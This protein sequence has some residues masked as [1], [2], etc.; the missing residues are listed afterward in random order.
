MSYLLLNGMKEKDSFFFKI[1]EIIENYL[2]VK[3]VE[4]INLLEKEIKPCLG[5]FKCWVQTPGICIIDDFGRDVAK[6]YIQSDNVIYLTSIIFGNFSSELKK[7]VDRTLPLTSPFF[8]EYEGTMCHESRYNKYPNLIAFGILN[9]PDKTEEE[10]FHSL[11]EKNADSRFSLKKL[12]KVIY[13]TDDY[14]TIKQKIES[15][16]SLGRIKK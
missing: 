15:I 2:T 1:I 3:N 12:S 4:T 11:V 16:L 7:A 10:I 6:K 8:D 5:C 13:R 9:N 14:E